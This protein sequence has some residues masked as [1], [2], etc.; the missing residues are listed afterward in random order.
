MD[1]TDLIERQDQTKDWPDWLRQELER[2]RFNGRVGQNLVSETDRVRVWLIRLRPGERLP[3]HCHVLDYF[4]TATTAGAA[5]SH[6]LGGETVERVYAEGETQHQ[7]FARGEFK[8]H[9]LENIG[10]G[11]LA[12]TTVEFL[13]GGNAPLALAASAQPA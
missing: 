7:R 5:R 11:D 10:D 9:D 12:F 6:V 4:W 8:I 2:N 3:L 1:D 13:G